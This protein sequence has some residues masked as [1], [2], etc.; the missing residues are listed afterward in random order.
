MF[1]KWWDKG[2]KDW[3]PESPPSK[4]GELG[5]KEVGGQEVGAL[6][7]AGVEV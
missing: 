4:G 5:S 3:Y 7:G 1:V 2:A 6:V